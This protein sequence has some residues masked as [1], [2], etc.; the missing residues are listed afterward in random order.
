MFF[1]LTTSQGTPD[2]LLFLID[3]YLFTIGK[4][5]AALFLLAGYVAVQKEFI[6]KK[7]HMTLKLT[8]EVYEK[9]FINIE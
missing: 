5:V 2:W 6:D 9:Q 4:G 3:N 7:P 1:L 8:N